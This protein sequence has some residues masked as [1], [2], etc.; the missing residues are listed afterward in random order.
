MTRYRYA[1]VRPRVRND[2]I[3]PML[4][5]AEWAYIAGFFD[6]EAHIG[7]HWIKDRAR[8]RTILHPRISVPQ[9]DIRPLQW[10]YQRLGGHIY[11]RG[12]V[13]R[14]VSGE[15]KKRVWTWMLTNRASIYGVLQRL[16]PLLIVKDDQAARLI[17]LLAPNVVIVESDES[18]VA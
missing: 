17:A 1:M 16:H 11:E 14:T 4:S 10:I 3:V 2:F 5:D 13:G 7:A 8:N 15:S 6:G 9:T 12:S 18:R